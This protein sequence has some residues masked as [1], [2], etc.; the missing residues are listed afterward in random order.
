MLSPDGTPTGAFATN[1]YGGPATSIDIS[2]GTPLAPG[3]SVIWAMELAPV[4]GYTNASWVPGYQN[5][6]FPGSNPI[7]GTNASIMCRIS[8]PRAT[9]QATIPTSCP[10]SRRSTPP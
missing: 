8:I 2:L 9:R 3:Q 5:I 7:P 10:A 1:V 6:L 4:N